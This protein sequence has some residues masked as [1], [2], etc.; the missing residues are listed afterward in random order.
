[1]CLA[2]WAYWPSL[3]HAPKHDQLAYLAEMAQRP[4]VWDRTA[5]AYSW[6]RDRLFMK[7]DELLFRPVLNVFAGIELWLFGYDG[8]YWQGAALVLHL[9]TGVSLYRLLGLISAGLPAAAGAGIFL[10]M[11]ANIPLVVWTAVSGYMVFCI[12]LLE[13][14][15]CFLRARYDDHNR[16]RYM[17]KCFVLMTAAMFTYEAGIAGVAVMAVFLLRTAGFRRWGVFFL[18]AGAGYCTASVLDFQARHLLVNMESGHLWERVLSGQTLVN[19]GE[20]MRWILGVGVFAGSPDILPLDRVALA[21]WTLNRAWPWHMIDAL[22][23]CWVAGIAVWLVLWGMSLRDLGR[24]GA[25]GAALAGMM[26]AGFIALISVGR[27]NTRGFFIGL[28]FN[29]YYVYLIWALLIPAGYALVSFDRLRSMP[30]LAW[31][32][33]CAYALCMIFILSSAVSVRRVNSMIARYDRPRTDLVSAMS[34]FVRRHQGE[35]DFTFFLPHSCPGNYPGRWLRRAGDPLW[36][37]YTLAEVLYPRYF[38]TKD[39]KYVLKCGGF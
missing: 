17:S 33:C 14:I 34:G 24:N 39:P 31:L 35:K 3:K 16:H 12:L 30:G 37:R 22:G 10:V 36:R 27:V 2:L 32:R 7:G 6:H 26:A 11:T 15:I 25:R 23:W 18:C 20:V 5:G 29:A 1:M 19:I 4:T 21:P 9:L 28:A 38:I 13:G 8:R